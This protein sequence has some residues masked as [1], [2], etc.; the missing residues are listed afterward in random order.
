MCMQF[1]S[2]IISFHFFVVLRHLKPEGS[3][4][5]VCAFSGSLSRFLVGLFNVIIFFCVWLN[6]VLFYANFE[7]CVQLINALSDVLR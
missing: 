5:L 3:Q 7:G 1:V 2:K 4:R 6:N